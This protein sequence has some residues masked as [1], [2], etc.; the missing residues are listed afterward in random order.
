MRILFP[1]GDGVE[2]QDPENQFVLSVDPITGMLT[3]IQIDF[4]S[5]AV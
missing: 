5:I 3:L 2:I 4:K 1:A